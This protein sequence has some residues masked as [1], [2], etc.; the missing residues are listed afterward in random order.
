[1]NGHSLTL[2]AVQVE[3]GQPWTLPSGGLL[4]L[5]PQ[6]GEGVCACGASTVPVGPGDVV[7]CGNAMGAT[8]SVSKGKHFQAGWF[9]VTLELLYPLFG[10]SEIVHL[11]SFAERFQGLVRYRCGSQEAQECHRVLGG[12]PPEFNLDHRSRLL[13]VVATALSSQLDHIH[14]QQNGLVTQNLHFSKVVSA[15]SIDDLQRMGIDEL[16]GQ[17]GCSRRH[18][19]RL[20]HKY[21]GISVADLRR[22]ARL[23][24]ALCLLR[25]PGTKIM[26]I[27]EE[28]GFNHLGLFNSSFKR[29]FGASPG[30]LRKEWAQAEGGPVLEDETSLRDGNVLNIAI[31][32]ASVGSACSASIPHGKARN[33]AQGGR[34]DAVKSAGRAHRAAAEW[35]DAKGKELLASVKAT[36]PG[37]SFRASH[38]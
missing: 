25:H 33:G 21:F 31:S 34:V 26:G 29:R 17:F 9:S 2:R 1:M 4:F 38:S 3:S 32:K 5:L 12:V 27:A 30:Q 19:N 16:A 37:S 22:E 20:F 23:L 8:L 35:L 36:A 24:K 7:V 15:L 14:Q 6:G 13:R 18:L 28:C 11:H 10:S